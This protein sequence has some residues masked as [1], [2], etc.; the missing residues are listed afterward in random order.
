M[1]DISPTLAGSPRSRASLGRIIALGVLLG[2][3]LAIAVEIGRMFL[4]RNRHEVIPGRVYRSAQLSPDELERYVRKHNIRTVVN[5]R[6][7]PAS[8]WYPAEARATQTLGISQEDIT[9]SA[10][11]LPPIGE[12]RQLIDVFDHS[13]YPM[14]IHCQQ[15]ADR[16]GLAAA[17]YMLLHTDADF[18]KAFRQ[19]SPRYG[20]VPLAAT[21]AMDEFFDLYERWLADHGVEHSPTRFRNWATRVYCPGHGRARLEWHSAPKVVE[22]GKPAV[23]VLRAYNTSSETW[24]FSAGSRSGVHASYVVAATNGE[25]VFSGKAGFMDATVPPGGFIDLDLPIAANLATGRYFLWVD[26]AD[27]KASFI[28]Y[29]SEPLTHDWEARDPA[30]V[31]GQ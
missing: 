27:R 2:A 7:R 26:M 15:G 12:V 25:T 29:G 3:A 21:A 8:D 22:T 10:S 13:E 5:L 19:C 28:Q 23:F 6:G 17:I 14:L 4:D 11:R 9:T 18:A 31:R 24:R 30:P 20:H 16:T 1:P